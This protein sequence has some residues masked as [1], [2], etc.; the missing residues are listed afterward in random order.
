M[1]VRLNIVTCNLTYSVTYTPYKGADE[2]I[3]QDGKNY[4]ETGAPEQLR[5]TLGMDDCV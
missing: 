2:R 1:K 4:G 3:C 5:I